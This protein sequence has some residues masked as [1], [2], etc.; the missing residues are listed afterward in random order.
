MTLRALTYGYSGIFLTVGSAG[1][2]SSTVLCGSRI[3]DSKF[4]GTNDIR[5]HSHS[6]R[7]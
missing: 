7:S 1:F 6:G 2:I 5:P 4:G 3:Q